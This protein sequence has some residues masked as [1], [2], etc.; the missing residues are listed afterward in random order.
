MGS[1]PSSKQ[2]SLVPHVTNPGLRRHHPPSKWAETW[3]FSTSNGTAKR[4]EESL[5][6]PSYAHFIGFEGCGGGRACKKR[7]TECRPGWEGNQRWRDT[8]C[9]RPAF[10]E[11]GILWSSEPP[12]TKGLEY[13]IRILYLKREEHSANP[14]KDWLRAV[15][16]EKNEGIPRGP[17]RPPVLE[18][19]LGRRPFPLGCVACP[20]HPTGVV[21]AAGWRR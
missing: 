1:A 5:P 17:P 19:V 20:E 16:E 11:S 18:S 13:K 2:L 3:P 7:S 14:R 4:K 10:G 9:F 15:V 21:A 6:Q 12:F 8:R